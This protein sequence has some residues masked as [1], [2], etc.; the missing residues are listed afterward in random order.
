MTATEIDKRAAAEA[1]SPAWESSETAAARP[2]CGAGAGS[3]M[4]CA[5]DCW[6]WRW[7]VGRSPPG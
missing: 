4:G 2:G 6:W 5:W 7:A 1:P 3:S